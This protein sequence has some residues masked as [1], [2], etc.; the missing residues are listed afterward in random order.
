MGMEVYEGSGCG[1]N[2][3]TM[4]DVIQCKKN[5]NIIKVRH[6]IF[7][8]LTERPISSNDQWK[9]TQTAVALMLILT[10]VLLVVGCVGERGI[11]DNNNFTLNPS[12]TSSAGTNTETTVDNIKDVLVF[13]NEKMHWNLSPSQIDEYSLGMENGVRK[14]YRTIQT[15]PMF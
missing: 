13:W 10:A 2:K 11:G 7:N 4:W 6:T 9:H 3:Y 5:H 12:T 8:C 1:R 14:K 15:I